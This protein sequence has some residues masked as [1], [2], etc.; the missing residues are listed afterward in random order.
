MSH[1]VASPTV[2]T[3]PAGIAPMG[4]AIVTPSLNRRDF[5]RQTMDWTLAA[6]PGGLEYVVVD[7]GSSD[8]SLEIIR[9]RAPQLAGYVSEPDGGL[10][11]AIN[12]GF[13][14]TRGEIMGWIN[15]G[16]F[17]F[18]DSLAVVR[19]I[20]E[21]HPQIEWV[22]SRVLSFLDE[23][24]RLVEQGVHQGIARDSF[25][26]GEHLEGFSKGRSAS[27]IQ[28]ESTFWRRSLWERAGGR[29]DTSLSLAADFELWH[30]FFQHALLWS[31]SAPLGAFRRHADQLSAVQRGEYLAQA[32]SVLRR[33]GA[34]PRGAV[35]QTLS[36]GLRRSLPRPL[37]SSAT[38]LGLFQPAPLCSFDAG[39]QSWRLEW[40]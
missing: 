5:L 13:A 23:K 33:H 28:Q 22:T 31:V 39:S 14:R 29:L 3:A 32:E 1:P 6:D 18:P 20:F 16:D 7:G 26:A 30:R 35:A 10:Y 17:L 2:R 12:K 27:F 4:I 37:R 40:L 25:L 8:G 38:R 11:D 19:E 24:G 9:E 36:V 34:C 21:T 15:A